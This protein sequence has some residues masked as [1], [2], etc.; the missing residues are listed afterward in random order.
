MG[1]ILGKDIS[2]SVMKIQRDTVYI[3]HIPWWEWVK[4]ENPDALIR[5]YLDVI[6]SEVAQHVEA[7]EA[8]LE[9]GVAAGKPFIRPGERPAVG[10]E[11][12]SQTMET[13][14]LLQQRVERLEQSSG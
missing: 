13:V 2:D 7:I 4:R 14:R 5:G 1:S 11:A 6:V 8:H 9:E 12:L 10:G 3:S